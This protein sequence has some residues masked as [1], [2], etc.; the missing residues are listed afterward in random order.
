MQIFYIFLFIFFYKLI[1]NYI[2]LQQIRKYHVLHLNWLN[3]KY[4]KMYIHHSAV[5]KLFKRANL[6]NNPT[7]VHTDHHSYVAQG[8]VD[9]FNS[10]PTKLE[11]V[12][13]VH[14]KYYELS[15]SAFYNRIKD[16]FNPLYWLD[17]IIFAPKHLLDYLNVDSDKQLYKLFNILFTFLWWA[18]VFLFTVYKQ[19]VKIAIVN[20][21]EI[22]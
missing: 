20:L 5:I 14:I 15:E 16:C 13:Y 3:G 17:L 19:E 2:Y 1:S 11:R 9:T 18:I 6:K 22:L 21:I 12:A 8:A 7:P 4:D 10:F